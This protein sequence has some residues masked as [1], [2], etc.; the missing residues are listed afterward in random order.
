MSS[1]DAL[2]TAALELAPEDRLALS[3]RLLESIPPKDVTLHPAWAEEFRQRLTEYDAGLVQ[4]ISWDQIRTG[5]DRRLAGQAE[6][7][8]G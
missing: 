3:E 4:A 2:L 5:A 6:A 1:T 7:H 8:G